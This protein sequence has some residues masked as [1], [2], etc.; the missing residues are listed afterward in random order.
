MAEQRRVLAIIP[1]RGGS[2]RLPR[3]NVLPLGG[4][5]LIVWTIDAALGSNIAARTIVSSDDDEILEV[6][7]YYGATALKRSELLASDTAKT[8]DVVI[9]CLRQERQQGRVYDDVVLLQ[10]TS[11]LRSAKS[12][13]DA[14]HAYLSR[15][16]RSL[17]SV[18]ELDHPAEWNGVINSDGELVGIDFGSSKRSQDIRPSYRLNGAIYI[19]A[20]E[21]ILSNESFY[22]SHVQAFAMPR[23]DSVDIDTE[24]DFVFCKAVLDMRE[25]KG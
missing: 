1:A 20:V 5:P 25:Q 18:C 11:P 24:L 13:A 8:I 12:V 7:K 21:Q 6:A 22:T 16:D 15:T 14:Y 3:K 10:P 23:L 2:K 17:V 19:F 4:K 9:D